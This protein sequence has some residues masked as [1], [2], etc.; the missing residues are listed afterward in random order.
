MA[1][2]NDQLASYRFSLMF[3][4][5]DAETAFLDGKRQGLVSTLR[6]YNFMGLLLI[7]GYAAIVAVRLCR[8][9]STELRTF[10]ALMQLSVL[11][12]GVACC[13]VL[14]NIACLIILYSRLVEKVSTLFLEILAC[15]QMIFAILILPAWNTF[16]AAKMAGI[17]PFEYYADGENDPYFSD[18]RILMMSAILIVCSHCVVPMRWH[19]LVILEV[20]ISLRAPIYLLMFEGAE[21]LTESLQNALN[22]IVMTLLASWGKRKQDA[23]ERTVRSSYLN[24]KTMRVTQEFAVSQLQQLQQAQA[25]SKSAEVQSEL[26]SSALTSEKPASYYIFELDE[27]DEND[28][29][30]VLG[31]QL[32]AMIKLG[33]QENWHIE[34][35]QLQFSPTGLLGKGGFGAVMLGSYARA[36]VALKTHSPR[37]PFR[38]LKALANE[39]RIM[40]HIRH[41]CIVT[42]YGA[43]VLPKSE[44]LVLCEEYI[45]G[46]DL[47]QSLCKSKDCLHGHQRYEVLLDV[48]NALSYL[49]SSR[50]VHGDVKPHNVILQG[51][52]KRAKLVD[53]GLSIGIGWRK[54]LGGSIEWMAPELLQNTALCESGR[55]SFI[56]GKHPLSASTDI[57]SFGRL[58]FFVTTGEKPLAGMKKTDLAHEAANGRVPALVWPETLLPWQAEAEV[59]CEECLCF[60]AEERLDAL[61]LH[62]RVL[63]WNEETSCWAEMVSLADA[64]SPQGLN[65]PFLSDAP[66]AG[67]LVKTSLAL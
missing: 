29:Q 7:A 58:L 16:Y 3:C 59:L 25:N 44:C 14:V 17:D 48:C 28:E 27:S 24:E 19:T 60:Q 49:H 30:S 65:L 12:L 10:S 21:P 47:Y 55:K 50:I 15:V 46:K 67:E 54:A 32:Q 38:A 2:T 42:F 57:F 18:S 51:S 35:D 31:I 26:A 6:A 23:F 40:R 52:G 62:R 61:A 22:I 1:E 63:S 13:S 53:F 64:D 43:C 4:D 11:T 33:Q 45:D 39:L 9:D 56:T 36:A 41:P 37:Q 8:V 34:S 66:P 20:I 5:K